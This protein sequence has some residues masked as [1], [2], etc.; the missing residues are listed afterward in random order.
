MKV[1]SLSGKVVEVDELLAVNTFSADI[2]KEK[3]QELFEQL[4]AIVKS[5]HY[6]RVKVKVNE[7]IKFVWVND[8]E[9]K[10]IKKMI[11]E[12]NEEIIRQAIA[13]QNRM[14]NSSDERAFRKSLSF[15]WRW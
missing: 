15:D 14:I 5:S 13:Q 12:E 9:A 1:K 7:E 8:E 4:Q 6:N 3:N 10:K 2:I 11:E